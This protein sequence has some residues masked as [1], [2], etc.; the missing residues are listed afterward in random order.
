MP[1]A[2]C[3]ACGRQIFYKAGKGA[4]AAALTGHYNAEHLPEP[5]GA[6]A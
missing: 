3:E 2:R 4:A 6:S 5:A 1:W